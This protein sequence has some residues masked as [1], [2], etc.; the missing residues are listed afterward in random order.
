MTPIEFIMHGKPAPVG[1]KKAF[2][3]RGKGGAFRAIVTDDNRRSRPWMSLVADA[4]AQAWDAPPLACAVSVSIEFRMP[5]PKSHYRTGKNSDR[6]RDDAPCAH[7]QT[8][9][10]DKLV[11]CLIDGI[12]GI[13]FADD[14]QVYEIRA[15]KVWSDRPGAWVQV[16][17]LNEPRKASA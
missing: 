9:D 8:P 3:V 15:C 17:P 16:N 1:S 10:I 2:A 13:V 14:R 6:L 12:S 4:A 5:R 11:R 7:A